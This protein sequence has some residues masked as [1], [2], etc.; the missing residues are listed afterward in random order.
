MGLYETQ[1]R[2]GQSET[3]MLFFRKKKSLKFV[4]TKNKVRV[5]FSPVFH[6]APFTPT[7]HTNS[8]SEL[9]T[10]KFVERISS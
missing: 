3:L 2:L 5:S 6:T 4:S 7:Y 10:K 1:N 9:E 8:N